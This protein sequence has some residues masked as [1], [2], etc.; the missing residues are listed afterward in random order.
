MG[1]DTKRRQKIRPYKIIL[2]K[3]FQLLPN[4]ELHSSHPLWESQSRVLDKFLYKTAMELNIFTEPIK[5]PTW[6][7]K[8]KNFIIKSE[9]TL[10]M[11]RIR[12]NEEIKI[13]L[14]S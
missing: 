7:L 13:L 8:C 11:P 4:G 14:N 9:L 1:S 6:I 12:S 10:Y 2:L 5:I 3:P